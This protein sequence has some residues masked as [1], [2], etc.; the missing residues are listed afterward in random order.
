MQQ[1]SLFPDLKPKNK[2]ILYVVGNGFDI[3]HGIKSR[4]SDFKEWLK[5]KGRD[6]LISMM[7][8]FF[9]NDDSFWS[10]TEHSLG[11]YNERSIAE[12]CNPNDTI[13]YDH[14]TQYTI[15]YEDSPDWIFKPELNDFLNS[16]SEWVDSIDISITEQ[17]WALPTESKYLTFNY[18]ETLEKYYGIPK[19]NICH[20]HGSR[21]DN[22]KYIIGHNNFCDP[23]NPFDDDS[24][25]LY[26]QE[27]FS[28]I[29][30][31][32]NDLY[33]DTSKIIGKHKSFFDSLC[34]IKHVV[35]IGFSF[36]NIDLP[37]LE[38]IVKKTGRDTSW[39]IY[40]HTSE[41]EKAIDSFITRVGLEKVR[42]VYK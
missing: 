32:M 18:T 41:D 33:K 12:F 40:Y 39:L 35:V 2:S 8:I 20:I 16:F 3:S 31:W 22:E 23:N 9:N 17:K 4:Y 36:S 7:D 29:I 11:D 19:E 24:K 14:P 34:G 25:L 26:Q 1:L 30:R 21:L 27:T 6:R 15:A 37:Y 13:D 28:K 42:K 10:D 5:Q 38:E